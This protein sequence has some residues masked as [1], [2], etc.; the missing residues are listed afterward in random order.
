MRQAASV[1]N[2]NPRV[3]HMYIEFI[4]H[5][6]VNYTHTTFPSAQNAM[7]K[8]LACGGLK[9]LPRALPCTQHNIGHSTLVRISW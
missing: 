1:M 5:T 7:E 8:A 4:M 3:P 2:L 6:M 9:C